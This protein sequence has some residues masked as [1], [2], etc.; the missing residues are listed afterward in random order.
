MNTCQLIGRMTKDPEVRYTQSGTAMVHFNIAIDRPARKDGTKDT[1]FPRVLA[2]GST[3]EAVGRY[4]M[5]GML[6]GVTGR[7]QTG[8]YTNREGVKV[9]TTEVLAERVEFLS[10][11]ERAQ[12][13]A[14][15]FA[16]Q[17]QPAQN[18]QLNTA[19]SGWGQF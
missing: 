18:T 5:Q 6:V 17:A 13:P 1:D 9:Y 3:A 2:L 14:N 19:P 15:A 10:K 16:P 8:D 11:P 12:D 7:I 4:C